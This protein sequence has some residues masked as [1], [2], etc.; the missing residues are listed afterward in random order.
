VRA[1]LNFLL[2]GAT[3]FLES[4]VI[5]GMLALTLFTLGLISLVSRHSLAVVPRPDAAP[6][7]FLLAVW[8]GIAL[9]GWLLGQVGSRRT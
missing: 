7:T 2:P 8:A 3:A 4:R 5:S 1:L 9:L 6:P